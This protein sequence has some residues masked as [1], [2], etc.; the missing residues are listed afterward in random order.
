MSQYSQVIQ[1]SQVSQI[2]KKRYLYAAVGVIM[3]LFA[4]FVYAW[5]ILSA[6]IAAEFPQWSNAQLSLTFTICMAFFCLGGIA[7]GV[8]SKRIPVRING[9]LSAAL[10]LVG[11]FLTSRAGSLPLLYIGYGVLCGSASGFAYNAVMNV[12]PQWFPNQQGTISGVLLLGFGASSMIIGAAFTA[13]TPDEIG[14]WRT[15]ILI[16]GV[17]MAAVIFLG[18]FFLTPPK[19]GELPSPKAG[20]AQGGGLDLT[21][22]QMLKRPSFW[23]F[24]LWATLL[25]AVG[26]VIIA[27][28]RAIAL[29]AAPAMDAGTLSFAVGL[30]SV[31]NGLGRVLF[32]ALFDKIGRRPTMLLV[33]VCFVLGAGLIWVS[34]MG[35]SALLVA[36][37]VFTGLGY[38]G[39][40]TMGASVTK[41]FYGQANYPVNFSVMN[42]NLLV[43]S[44]A[45]TA[46]GAIYDA[47]G[48]FLT[49][50][51]LLFVMLA[52]ALL[53]WAKLR[54]A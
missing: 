36:G 29:T 1:N 48:S 7:A 37:F 17:I 12:M 20:S 21:P 5:S 44:F 6:P 31:C 11:F 43:A 53:A 26:L 34:L 9:F 23:L 42:V 49:V 15:S 27:Q 8:L 47:S 3:L 18:S 50:F 24:F 38:G 22:G 28:A 14:A 30:I 16:L 54:Q 52:V 10:F 35:S 25:S 41:Q 32:G 39:G 40:P 51:V 2:S 45:S 13:A 46:A 33:I 4:G 19:A